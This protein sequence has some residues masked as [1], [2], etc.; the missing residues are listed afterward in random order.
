MA[1]SPPP[2]SFG[3]L[4]AILGAA[5]VVGVGVAVVLQIIL[6]IPVVMAVALGIGLVYLLATGATEP[7]VAAT[8]VEASDE[9]PFEDPVEEAD[10]WESSGTPHEPSAVEA[11]APAPA[12]VPASDGNDPK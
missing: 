3:S 10:L 4:L 7:R 11:A 1:T 12:A 9:E 5:T 6:L 2:L 8:T